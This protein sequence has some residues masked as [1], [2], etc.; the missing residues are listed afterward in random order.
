MF[1]KLLQVLVDTSVKLLDLVDKG[2]TILAALDDKLKAFADSANA[3][4]AQA[5]SSLDNIVADEA[6]LSKQI[7]D[8]KA[9]LGSADLT[10]EQQAL[11][12]SVSTAASSMA[13]R[14][15]AMADAVPDTVAPPPAG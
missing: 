14:T 1:L 9:L 7:E 15:K 12:D 3:A 6:N 11:L 13:A 8:L 4:L 2:V 5:N 10:P